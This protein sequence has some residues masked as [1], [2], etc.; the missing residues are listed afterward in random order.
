MTARL[1]SKTSRIALTTVSGSSNGIYSELLV[2]KICL[3]FVD[4]DSKRD[5]AS[6]T[7]YSYLRCARL[8]GWGRPSEPTP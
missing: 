3:A 6:V 2:A 4:S 5:W 7:S 1:A 8:L